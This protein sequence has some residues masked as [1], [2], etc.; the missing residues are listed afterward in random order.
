MY[1]IKEALGFDIK[2]IPSPLAKRLTLRVDSKDRIPVLSIPKYCSAKKAIDFVL[3]N[4]EWLD[5]QL[6][7]VPEPKG[8]NNKDKISLMGKELIIRHDASLRSGVFI[9]DNVLHVSGNIEFLNRRVRDFVKA[10]AKKELT[11]LSQKKAAKIGCIIN[12]VVI[13]DTKSRWG[14]CSSNNN[15]NYS[16]RIVLAPYE[17]IDYLVSHEVSHL[18]HQDHSREFWK[19]VKSLHPH[20]IKN[21]EWL[22]IHGKELYIY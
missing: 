5:R 12:S 6:S 20:Y 22:K 17:V 4:N 16:W 1:K 7:M 14:S 13:K 19:C 3:Q 8:F 21:R 9:E 15:I 10:I 18:K 2:I 11:K